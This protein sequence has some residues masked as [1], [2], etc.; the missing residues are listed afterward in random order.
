MS[1][2]GNIGQL[3]IQIQADSDL[4]VNSLERLSSAL[5]SLTFGNVSGLRNFTKEFKKLAKVDLSNFSL[6]DIAN[7]LGLFNGLNIEVSG[8]ENL[9]KSL[10]TLSN[11]HFDGSHLATQLNELTQNINV[12]DFNIQPFLDLANAIK[13]LGGKSAEKAIANMP[14]LAQSVKTLL[15]QMAIVP[16]IKQN[17]IDMVNALANF[18]AQGGKVGSASKRIVK[19]LQDIERQGKKTKG[20]I[21]T[22]FSGMRAGNFAGNLAANL[23]S[24]PI[25]MFANF[26]AT[27]FRD[28]LSSATEYAS[29]IV[30]TQNIIERTF[31]DSIDVIEDFSKTSLKMYGINELEAKKLTGIYQAMGTSLG[32]AKDR[33]SSV[34]TSLTAL[35]ADY[36]SFFNMDFSKVSDDFTAI[37]TG[38][39]KAMRKYGIDLTNAQLQSFA[40][41]RGW[42]VQVKSLNQYQKAIIR[43]N[44]LVSRS[45]DIVGDFERTQ[46]SF[47][48]QSRVLWQQLTEAVGQFGQIATSI[49]K[50]VLNILNQLVA[51][52]RAF[53]TALVQFLGINN[54]DFGGGAVE[55]LAD[56]LDDVDDS[57]TDATKS[58]KKMKQYTTSIDELNV[59]KPQDD[60]SSSGSGL[61]DVGK[62]FDWDDDWFK[63]LEA[64]EENLEKFLKF[65]QDVKDILQ[66]TID[67]FKN[68][69]REVLDPLANVAWEGLK[70]L[71]NEVLLPIS[72]LI[73]TDALP[74]LFNFLADIGKKIKWDVVTNAVK[75]LIE[76]LGKATRGIG[77]GLVDF[78]KSLYPILKPII[79]T[80][81]NLIAGA[82]VKLTDALK[83]IPN[84]VFEVIGRGLGV[85]LTYKA[86]NGIVL[87][88]ATAIQN[89]GTALSTLAIN[90]TLL[91]YAPKFATALFDM[92]NAVTT[93]GAS[94]SAIAGVVGIIGAIA[95]A[96]YQ[97]YDWGEKLRQQQF[98]EYLNKFGT[99]S[100]RIS[101]LT[102]NIRDLNE[103]GDKLLNGS[104][105]SLIDAKYL[106]DI[107]QKYFELAEKENLSAEEQSQLIHYANEMVKACPE[108]EK[109][110]DKVTGAYT[111]TKDE[112]QKVINKTIQLIQAN[113]IKEWATEVEK[114][115]IPARE[116]LGKTKD[117]LEDAR[118]KYDSMK[119]A[120]DDGTWD[121]SKGKLLDYQLELDKQGKLV[122]EL[123]TKYNNLDKEISESEGKVKSAIGSLYSNEDNK[124]EVEVT[125]KVNEEQ[126]KT[127]N[128]EIKNVLDSVPEEE[129]ASVNVGAKI[130]EKTQEELGTKT[131]ELVNTENKK[132]SQEENKLKMQTTLDT[133]GVEKGVAQVSSIIDE[134]G[135]ELSEKANEIG[136][137][138]MNSLS[139][140]LLSGNKKLAEVVTEN[141]TFIRT[142]ME[143]QF[144]ISGDASTVFEGYG[145]N[146]VQGFINGITLN[147]ALSLETI[148]MW[149]NKIMTTFVGDVKSGINADRWSEY[150]KDIINGFATGINKHKQYS[151]E[152][153]R[154]WVQDIMNTFVG[155]STFG[156][157]AEVWSEYA[158]QI[159]IG[160]ADGINKWGYIAK[161]AVRRWAAEIMAAFES[162]MDIGSPS[163]VFERYGGFTV[164]GFNIGLQ[165]NVDS[166]YAIIDNWVDGVKESMKAV[167]NFNIDLSSTIRGL[168]NLTAKV[169]TQVDMSG[170]YGEIEKAQTMGMST[171]LNA[172]SENQQTI[173]VEIPNITLEVDSREIARANYKGQKQLGYQIRK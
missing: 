162:E 90:K 44:Y 62:M 138:A 52:I 73:F 118:K 2:Y 106:E 144:G 154:I 145:Q 32:E 99:S 39:T 96:M 126:V 81:I 75:G 72:K 11:V 132:L 166:S 54:F 120:L 110:I 130:D 143:E 58:L 101:E 79:A 116:E 159:N 7:Q 108:L 15:T 89:M 95:I 85:F 27:S 10:R 80:T 151:L 26:I 1:R 65:F 107:S 31:G 149:V 88:I 43:Y 124:V 111:G 173:Q 150:A 55:A 53:A 64:S 86:V 28:L 83:K 42:D 134:K 169:S 100:E 30:E 19:G 77:Q 3:N 49:L 142:T 92:G 5:S 163:K 146:I 168:D 46:M 48:N 70:S 157:N 127:T 22:I 45:K 18:S 40:D 137:N 50:P 119:K 112:I 165:D 135:I 67:A 140:G 36:A 29:D 57:A 68:F 59:L 121:K 4:A 69:K 147:Q 20:I 16:T 14:L 103:E 171:S 94:I 167:E 141:A 97:L 160:F 66:P 8:L 139:E 25:K 6:G 63:P 78:F 105:D 156:I 91:D 136:T 23:L 161:E 51:K 21:G 98:D 56:G 128:S 115:L 104:S 122:D 34:S 131:T 82:I 123:T 38:Q 109:N 41:E 33:M 114:G 17:T 170:F 84:G 102:Q 47:A 24:S 129:R 113:A 148:T 76:V 35:A 153:V 13:Q 37:F 133:T 152:A 125:P 172:F 12:I 71:Y 9:S 164:E 117:A 93:F 61:G 87:G 60:S 158:H 74:S 155:D